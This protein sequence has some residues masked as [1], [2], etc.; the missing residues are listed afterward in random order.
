MR[1]LL[2]SVFSFLLAGCA[3]PGAPQPPSLGLP[4]PVQDLR[5]TR[6]GDRVLLTW[7]RPLETSDGERLKQVGVTRVCRSIG[8]KAPPD[9]A[10]PV[11][12]VEAGQPGQ[13]AAFVDRIPRDLQQPAADATVAYTLETL[14]DRGRSAGLSRAASVPL[15]TIPPAPDDLSARVTPDGIV[16]R[17]TG[18]PQGEAS[19]VSTAYR[20]FRRAPGAENDVL[21]GEVRPESAELRD[22]TF[23]WGA[24]YRYR[25]T[26]VAQIARAGQ[27]PVEIEGED[28]PLLEVLAEDRFPPAVPVGV[29]AVYSAVPRPA[30][31]R[32]FVDLTWSPSMDPDVAGY[33][34]W[35]REGGEWRK[36]NAGLVNT[37]AYRDV[38]IAPGTLEYAVSA[39]D[40]RGNESQRSEPA[41]EQVP[42][43]RGPSTQP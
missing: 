21:I 34:V 19:G 40:L 26:P 11:G 1:I 43:T 7:T 5:A 23:E 17:W 6:K 41:S 18:V 2:L 3:V 42:E 35:R 36:L 24:T 25:V 13:E 39:V 38:Q 22:P 37:P 32:G 10:Q 8:S 28:S 27:P 4:Q 12:E 14:N 31:P 15:V 9:C 29:E 20:V 33:N 16:L 30:A